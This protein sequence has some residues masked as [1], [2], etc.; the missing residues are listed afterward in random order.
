MNFEIISVGTEILLGQIVNT[1]AR[2]ISRLLSQLGINVF[3]TTVVGDNPERLKEA[4][5]V[6]A[7]RADGIITTGGLGPTKDDLTKEVIA[8]F[9]GL[10][11]VTHQE[12]LERLTAYFKNR[13]KYMADSN[14]KQ[15]EMPEG[16]IVLE[17]DFGTAPGAI[18]EGGPATI[19]ML[20]GPPSEMK[21][22]LYNKARPYL[23]KMSDS[24]ISSKVLRVFGVGESEA[25][26]KVKHII[27]NQTN[28]T[29]APYAKVG[30]MEFR[31]TAK[32]DSIQ[33]ANELLAPLEAQVR[34]ILGDVVYAEGED[35]TLQ[36]TVVELLRKHN[37]T[38]TFA[39]SCTGGLLAKKITEV[40]G[41]SECFNVSYV[42]YSNNEKERLLGV[43]SQTLE[44]YGAVS[45]QTA[46][47]MCRGAKAKA[48]ADIAV[49]VTGIAGPGGGS[50]EKPVGLVYVGICTDDVWE[51]KKLN[52]SGNRSAVRERTSL[53][54]LDAVR[55]Y[56]INL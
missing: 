6:A 42:T 53:Y 12:S 5:S 36:S 24:V 3:Y 39:E 11:C 52:L 48:S 29:I 22:M 46:L 45:H 51:Y 49:S 15:A 56:L 17:N 31:L 20:P 30:E 44:T 33:A 43:S 40:P 16:C 41:S 25:E 10:K 26:E 21:P 19:I 8:E 38:V 28:P 37:K 27:N 32:A 55:R 1:N 13:N 4:L 9:C 54:A 50:A 47:E 2:D 7:K 35:A 14:L 34:D 23:E 18:I